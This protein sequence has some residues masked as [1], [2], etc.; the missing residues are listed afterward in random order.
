M[1]S[2][3]RK[4]RPMLNRRGRAPFARARGRRHPVGEGSPGR[5]C[6]VHEAGGGSLISGFQSFADSFGTQII[7]RGSIFL[8]SVWEAEGTSGFCFTPF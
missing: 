4:R 6:P 7:S 2:E 1:H 5:I 3:A 8:G